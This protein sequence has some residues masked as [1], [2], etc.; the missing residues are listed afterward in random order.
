VRIYG[1]PVKVYATIEFMSDYSA[2]GDVNDIL[3]WMSKFERKPKQVFLV[4]GDDEALA[5]LK[6]TI[7]KRLRWSVTVPRARDV[8]T[9]E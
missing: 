8:F 4:H 5:A 2:H 3:G 7:E 1:E 6:E 9:L